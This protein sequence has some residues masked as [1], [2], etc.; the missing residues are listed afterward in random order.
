MGEEPIA[1]EGAADLS[2]IL[3]IDD[4]AYGTGGMH[5]RIDYCGDT[6]V[7]KAA[8]EQE[9]IR[10]LGTVAVDAIINIRRSGTEA[11]AR[12]LRVWTTRRLPA[13]RLVDRW[14]PVVC[15]KAGAEDQRRTEWARGTQGFA[16]RRL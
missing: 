15:E 10:L 16:D 11:D 13:V 14:T 9:A 12:K 1:K 4:S 8:T 7:I 5:V 6:V 3:V 2:D